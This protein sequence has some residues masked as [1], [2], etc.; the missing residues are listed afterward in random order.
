[1]K[2]RGFEMDA[3]TVYRQYLRG[4]DYLQRFEYYTRAEES[5]RFYNGDQWNGLRLAGDKPPALNILAPIVDYK[6]AIVAQKGMSINYSTQNYGQLY[7]SAMQVC[8]R[9][10][11][12]AKKTWERLKLDHL[13]WKV[14][15]EGAVTGD[16][17]LYF[18]EKNGLV[19][20][21]GVDATNIYFADEQDEELQQQKYIIIAQ[22]LFASDVREEARANNVDE[23]E[24]G[25][26]LPDSETE[27]QIG[28]KAK[29]EIDQDEDGKCLCFLK[30]WKEGGM[31]HF[32]R[33]TKNVIYQEDTVIE[34]LTKYPI[35]HFK[36]NSEKG[37][38][39]GIGEVYHRIPNQIEINKTLARN[40][41]SIK[42]T[43][44]PH[45]VYNKEKLTNEEVGRL[46]TVGSSIA[47]GDKTTENIRNVIGYME[48]AQINP[49]AINSIH[50]LMSSTRELAGAGD[51][52]TGNINPEQ[53]SGAAIIAV[54][55]ASAL[56]LTFQ[57][58]GFR[59]FVEDIALIWFDIW[60][61][62]NPNGLEVVRENKNIKT[63][64]SIPVVEV[65]PAQMLQD[66]KIEVRI[67]VSPSNPYSKFAQEQTLQNL[68]QMQ[69][70]SFED[71][72]AA[73]DDDSVAPKAK[74]KE[75]LQKQQ[76]KAQA[77][78]QAKTLINQQQKQENNAQ[79]MQ[80]KQ[81]G[82]AAAMV[83]Q[84][85]NEATE[86][87]AAVKEKDGNDEMEEHKNNEEKTKQESALG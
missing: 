24:I 13:V 29:E 31:V 49:I 52:A 12:Y 68:L 79:A 8:E 23:S 16:A 20:V 15:L 81:L 40:L 56:P 6:V 14:I 18:F 83:E 82:R 60:V 19:E 44:Y 51:A 59:Q 42:Q 61:A 39:R 57:M 41:A 30:M 9:L 33:C 3:N 25:L 75:I 11:S 58:A 1:M 71:Y 85:M 50:E 43:A 21:K 5:Y 80:Q 35:A 62:Y 4:R 10:N 36:W 7:Q 86:L 45:I 69:L 26:I 38:A 54:R 74:L 22:R 67:D 27:Y 47:V 32:L 87:K 55:D 76:L 34:G 17:F 28:D 46:S 37:S 78:M 73:L 70:I 63:G 64:S 77:Q 72:V 66:L 2:R 53:A 48:P 65:L 84:L